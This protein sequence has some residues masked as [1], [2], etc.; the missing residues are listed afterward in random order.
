MFQYRMS[1]LDNIYLRGGVTRIACKDCGESYTQIEAEQQLMEVMALGILVKPTKLSGSEMRFLRKSCYL[2]QEELAAKLGITRRAVLER[3]KRQDPGIRA[4][5][6]LGL[7]AILLASFKGRQE[8]DGSSLDPRHARMLEQAIRSFVAFTETMKRRSRRRRAT[9]TRD[10]RKK[11][12][13]FAESE[14]RAA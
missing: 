1:G 4:D 13:R 12:W 3:E 11:Q 8:K 14:A 2:S 5:Q 9:L 10:P 6:E 7:R